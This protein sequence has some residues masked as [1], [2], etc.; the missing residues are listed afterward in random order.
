MK[1]INHIKQDHLCKDKVDSF[2]NQYLI[3]VKFKIIL[4]LLDMKKRKTIKWTKKDYNIFYIILK[5]VVNTVHII[6][7][8]KQ[9]LMFLLL[10]QIWDKYHIF[11]HT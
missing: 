2:Q 3:L 8:K 11:N 5:S 4:V 9:K 7:M 10:H 1:N 6:V